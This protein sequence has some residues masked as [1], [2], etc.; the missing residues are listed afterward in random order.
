MCRTLI[1]PI[2]TSMY[3]QHNTTCHCWVVF[4]L[5]QREN[6]L[7]RDNDRRRA[8]RWKDGEDAGEHHPASLPNHCSC[9]SPDRGTR[10][11]GG[12]SEMKSSEIKVSSRAFAMTRCRTRTTTRV[13]TSAEKKRKREASISVVHSICG[14]YVFHSFYLKGLAALDRNSSFV[15][16]HIGNVRGRSKCLRI[17]R[18]EQSLILCISWHDK[19]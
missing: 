14:M 6:K 7:R 9:Q 8:R 19:I 13:Y 10:P 17:V 18:K 2:H 4:F 11:K 5:L 15:G 1:F 16:C 3:G 12:T